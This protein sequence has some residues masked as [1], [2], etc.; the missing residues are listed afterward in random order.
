MQS[1]TT[2]SLETIWAKATHLVTS[3]EASATEPG[4]LNF[5]FSSA[6]AIEEQWEHYFVSEAV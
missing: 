5:I 4:S 6:A 2:I 3:V 1:S